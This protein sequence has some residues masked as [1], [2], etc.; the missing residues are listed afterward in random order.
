MVGRSQRERKEGLDYPPLSYWGDTLCATKKQ[1]DSLR[2]GFV[3]INGF[4]SSADSAKDKQFSGYV[5]AYN[6]DVMGTSENNVNWRRCS[7]R[8]RSHERSR[9]WWQLRHASVAYNSKDKAMDGFYVQQGGTGVWT[10][11]PMVHRVAEKGGD[12]LGRWAWVKLRGRQD[13]TLTCMALYRPNP[14]QEDKNLS[15]VWSQ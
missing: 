11:G 4:G 7:V 15:S 2:I 13:Q 14:R 12:P 3:N 10:R 9:Q 1:K 8:D 6:F 5:R